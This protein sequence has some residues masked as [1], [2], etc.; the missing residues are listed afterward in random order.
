MLTTQSSMATALV[1]P[2]N[3][4]P[5]TLLIEFA[6]NPPFFTRLALAGPMEPKAQKPAAT[7]VAESVKK[8]RMVVVLLQA[9]AGRA[10]CCRENPA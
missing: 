1:P 4:E 10:S 2:K 5:K 7:A 6:A 9:I 3:D 8:R